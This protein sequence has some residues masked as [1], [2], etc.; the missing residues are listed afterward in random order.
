MNARGVCAHTVDRSTRLGGGRFGG[1]VVWCGRVDGVRGITM[2]VA[3][4]AA[5]E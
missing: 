3:T 2:N 1:G 5:A 4:A